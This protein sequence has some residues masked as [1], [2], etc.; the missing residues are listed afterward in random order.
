MQL[1]QNHRVINRTLGGIYW[2]PADPQQQPPADW[3]ARCGAEV[4]RPHTRLCRRCK[5]RRKE[6]KLWQNAECSTLPS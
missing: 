1:Y 2:Q 6:K 5:L 4:Y 3:C